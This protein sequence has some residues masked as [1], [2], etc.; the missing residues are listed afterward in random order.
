[1]RKIA[2]NPTPF[3]R[4][5]AK[6]SRPFFLLVLALSALALGLCACASDGLKPSVFAPGSC[7]NP[8]VGF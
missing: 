8:A 4:F 5:P 7:R 6:V 3:Q 2:Y 1:M